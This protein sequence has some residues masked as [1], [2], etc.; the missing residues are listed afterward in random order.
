MVTLTILPLFYVSGISEVTNMI[1]SDRS[2]SYWDDSFDSYDLEISPRKIISQAGNFIQLPQVLVEFMGLNNAVF[3]LGILKHDNYL[4]LKRCAKKNRIYY[5]SVQFYKNWGISVHRQKKALEQLSRCSILRETGKTWG[6]K[7]KLQLNEFG[8]IVWLTA[9][10]KLRSS[11]EFV[12]TDLFGNV[13]TKQVLRKRLFAEIKRLKKEYD[14]EEIHDS[15]P[16]VERFIKKLT[17]KY[18][19]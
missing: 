9:L 13:Q 5:S 10:N 6:N 18:D 8:I 11:N 14:L 4:R 17:A 1:K 2:S 19:R 3:L 16:G 7:R 15:L 12:L